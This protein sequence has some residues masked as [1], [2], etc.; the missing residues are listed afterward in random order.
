MEYLTIL[1]PNSP[2]DCCIFVL[3]Y[4]IL[5]PILSHYVTILWDKVLAILLVL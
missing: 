5:N 1:L 3:S 4:E 2:E